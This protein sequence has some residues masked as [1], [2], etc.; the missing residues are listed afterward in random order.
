M[1][2]TT[3]LAAA[4]ALSLALQA[5]AT[6]T[7]QRG[8]ENPMLDRQPA[9]N[10]NFRYRIDAFQVPEASRAEFEA[11]MNRSMTFLSTLPGCRGQAVLV[12]AA[13]PGRFDVITMATWESQ[14]AVDEAVT[15]VR[16]YYRSIGFDPA[17]A[18]A[19]WGVKAELGFYRSAPLPVGQVN[20]GDHSGEP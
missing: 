15:Q 11:A 3:R 12:K 8:T 17:A 16:A 18:M 1:T 14:E 20:S 9:G 7:N 13:G 10:P 2:P 4:A 5:C 19:R 6:V